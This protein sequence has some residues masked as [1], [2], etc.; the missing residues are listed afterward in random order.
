M[1]ILLGQE[2]FFLLQNHPDQFWGPPSLLFS[3]YKG[4]FMEVK[5]L[6]LEVDHSPASCAEVKNDKWLLFT[7]N[8]TEF[9]IM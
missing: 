3:G 8:T 9:D 4:S 7:I 1:Q 5:Q 2:I 6:G